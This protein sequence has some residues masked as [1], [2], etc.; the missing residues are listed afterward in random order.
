MAVLL[1]L[2]PEIE[3]DFAA[4][5]KA[6]GISLPDYLLRLLGDQPTEGQR[7]LLSPTERAAAWRESVEGLPHVPPLSDE[8][9][10]RVSIYDV[11][12]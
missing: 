11:C 5:A 10:S 8:A 2:P 9:I 7:R 12:D 6:Q 4:Q 3:A 1:D